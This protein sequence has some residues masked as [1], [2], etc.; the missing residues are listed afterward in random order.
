M[1]SGIPAGNYTVTITDANGCS[2]EASYTITQPTCLSS[3][4][5]KMNVKCNG[6]SDGFARIFVS[7]GTTPYTYLWSTGATTVS[8]HGR[9]AGMYTV[10]V[11]DAN[12]CTMVK[13]VTIIQ[14]TPIVIANNVN[15]VSCNGGANGA[16]A[17]TVTGGSTPY[18]YLWSNGETGDGISGLTSG[19]YSVTVTD[20]SNC[21]KSVT[22]V[23]NNVS[24][25]GL[26]AIYLTQPTCFT[27]DGEVEIVITGGTA[28][29]YYLGSNG[30]TNVTFDRNVSFS[31]LGPGFF[32]I[33]VVDA[34][35]C[36]FTTS[37]SLLT[38]KGMSIVSV[39]LKHSTCNN[40]SAVIGP[41]QVIGGTSPYTYSLTNSLGNTN[42]ITIYQSNWLFDGL[43]ADTYTL[44]I[45]DAG[46]CTFTS[47]YTI[48]NTSL[49]D[50][51]VSTT[52]T[53]CNNNNGSVRLEIT[54]GGTSPYVYEINGS[55][56]TTTLTSYTFNNLS[57][58][59][60]TASVT[61]KSFCKQTQ[62]FTIN[63]SSTTDFHLLGVDSFNKD[64]SVTA[65]ITNGEPPFTLYWSGD[66][67]GQTG[68]TVSDLSAGEYTLRVVDS[69]GCS[70]TK[71]VSINGS[72]N[73]TSTGYSRVCSTSILNETLVIE[74]GPKQLLNEGYNELISQT[75]DTNCILTAAT[76]Q[77]LVT[78]G[79]YSDSV[80]FY[81]S[82]G[83][84]DYPTDELWYNTIQTLLE[85]VPIIGSVEID[86][87]N[88][89]IVVLTNCDPESLVNADLR[90]V[91]RIDYEI[92]C[93]CATATPSLT[94]TKTP[95]PTPTITN[96]P[97]LTPKPTTSVTP[98]MTKTPTVTPT[99]T[100]TPTT[101]MTPTPSEKV[102]WYAY[103]ACGT[104]PAPNN[105]VIIQPFLVLPG[106]VIGN[107]FAELDVCRCY[108]LINSSDNLSQ[109]EGIY[110]NVSVTQ[111]T[112]YFTV[113]YPEIFI[114][115][116]IDLPCTQCLKTLEGI[117]LPEVAETCTLEIS[118]F[119]Y[120]SRA[121]TSGSVQVNGVVVYS[122]DNTF[123]VGSLT[124]PLNI[125]V[126]V[127]DI[128]TVTMTS[129]NSNSLGE[130][131]IGDTDVSGNVVGFY[132]S[133]TNTTIVFPYRTYCGGKKEIEFKSNCL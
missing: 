23:I 117:C 4:F 58:G 92:A 11:T 100:I 90:V 28:P 65:Y 26:G 40:L 21:S 54:S 124:P 77:A 46:S 107:V 56:I 36:T 96:T 35:L 83:L 24:Q 8:I 120:C 126:T 34:G 75:N 102:M 97:G 74:T 133:V 81:N 123:P 27:A 95:T 128:I 2:F 12:G 104:E 13:R 53:T 62:L 111:F 18:T 101:T 19:T 66:V 93:V 91:M 57:S 121:D 33:Q 110:Q 64:G 71:R 45:T 5:T 31:G 82:T 63:N 49:F 22:E 61:D 115:T 78:A 112:N 118:N 1:I 79:T 47:A 52:G 94:P 98:T 127:G 132:E 80:V 84:L 72:T 88:N 38:P 73:Y 25:V 6:G 60:Y 116:E 108:E 16:I 17:T 30:V 87:I 15:N 114:G 51:T 55:R 106:M 10:T 9:T 76:F 67:G 131:T 99:M 44:S 109:L 70:K 130:F 48:N 125:P 68:L 129:N 43:S 39:D 7:G 103:L 86:P 3:Y 69:N 37:T 105:Q 32:S 29:F 42:S 59:N 113:V 50:L 20:S 14:P 85:G 41:I 122:F 89:T 119:K